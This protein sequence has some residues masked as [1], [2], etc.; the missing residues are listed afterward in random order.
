LELNRLRIKTADIEAKKEKQIM[1]SMDHFTFLRKEWE[2]EE[3][4]ISAI[5]KVEHLIHNIGV[6]KGNLLNVIKKESRLTTSPPD[7][8]EYIISSP[9][10]CELL[11]SYEELKLSYQELQNVRERKKEGN[12]EDSVEVEEGRRDERE[13]K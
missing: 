5:S 3:K 9:E 13:E 1:L 10:Y 7:I 12:A 6:I 11:K 4:S 2:Q 8:H